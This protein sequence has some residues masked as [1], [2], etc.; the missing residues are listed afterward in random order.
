MASA[1]NA[2]GQRAASQ[3]RLL[4]LDLKWS[5]GIE[6]ITAIL[7]EHLQ[8][9]CSVAVV[10][11]RESKLPY[12][13]KIAASRRYSQM[14]VASLNP[15][16]WRQISREIK[17]VK[18][19]VLYIISP[20]ILNSVIAFYC[21][22]FTNIYVISH[23]H[24]PSHYGKRAISSLVNLLSFIQSKMSHRV[25]CWGRVIRDSICERFHI[26]TEKVAVFRHG[27][28]QATWSDVAMAATGTGRC[29]QFAMVGELQKR[30][31]IVHFLE[32][33]I[34]VNQ[35][36]GSEGVKFVLAGAGE[37]GEYTNIMRQIPNLEVCNRFVQDHE[38]NE[39][40]NSSCVLVLPYIGGVLQSSFIAIAYGNGCP[41]IVSDIGSLAEEVECGLTGFVVKRGN[42]E[43]LAEAMGEIV[44]RGSP[45]ALS[46]NCLRAYREKFSWE[47]IT[48]AMY[49]DMERAMKAA[50]QSGDEESRH[51]CTIP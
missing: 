47:R 19:D 33:A 29:W 11:A 44:K 51:A 15:G 22:L 6:A 40:L 25:Y 27:P 36:Y 10:S 9:R 49:C 50:K 5:Y 45:S 42:S 35:T 46:E 21:R 14:L 3:M 12:S 13:L 23:I 41:V 7:Y 39:I 24:D 38:I 28:G 20:H 32:A 37:L 4:I 48:D 31:G 18:P 34:L 16:V 30:K 8:E 2:N 17:R 26:A 43:A 1:I